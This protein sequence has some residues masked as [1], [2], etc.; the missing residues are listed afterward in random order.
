MPTHTDHSERKRAELQAYI[1]RELAPHSA[2]R[3]FGE[4]IARAS[5]IGVYRT[6]PID[7]AFLRSHAEPG[8]AWNMAAWYDEHSKRYPEK[9]TP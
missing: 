7:E 5:A 2:V 3:A 8:R 6:D 9:E 4:V 1:R